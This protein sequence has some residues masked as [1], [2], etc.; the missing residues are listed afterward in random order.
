[1][2]KP[3]SRAQLRDKPKL[4]VILLSRALHRPLI[5]APCP[6]ILRH[7]ALLSTVDGKDGARAATAAA[8]RAAKSS[9]SRVYRREGREGC[10][11]SCR[12]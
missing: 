7:W 9:R 10:R 6:E 8:R 12:P 1:M 3:I 2:A 5:N 4:G 11:E